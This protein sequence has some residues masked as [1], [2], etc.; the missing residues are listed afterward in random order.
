VFIRVPGS[1]DE[2]VLTDYMDAT[3]DQG[4][5]A[6][7]RPDGIDVWRVI[8]SITSGDSWTVARL[9]GAAAVRASTWSGWDILIDIETGR[10]QS[11]VFT[12]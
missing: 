9:E 11:R 6:R 2:I 7:V 12:K 4:N 5:L 8:P 1:G 10:E 3:P